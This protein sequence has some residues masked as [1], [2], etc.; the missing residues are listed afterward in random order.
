MKRILA[1]IMFGCC[2]A[3]TRAAAV[4]RDDND[5]KVDVESDR[6]FAL[7]HMR[8]AAADRLIER[9]DEIRAYKAAGFN[10]IVL[11]DADDGLLKSEER[12]AYETSFARAHGF[13]VV[14]GKGTEPLT[15][16]TSASVTSNAVRRPRRALGTAPLRGVSDDEIRERLRLWDQYAN[17]LV[18]GAFFLH[19]D[20]FYIRTPVERQRHLYQ[21]AHET[22]PD[23]YVFGMIGEGG[24]NA[25]DEEIATY[26][27]PKAFDHL[28]LIMYP[29]NTGGAAT[30]MPIDNIASPD[31][32][33]DMKVYVRRYLGVMGEK[34]IKR[35]R[36]EQLTVLV[37]QAFAYDGE[38]AGHFPRAADITI[39]AT[40]GSRCLREIPGQQTNRSMA[41][42]LWDGSRGGMFGLW[43]RNDWR[44]AAE[45]ANRANL[46]DGDK[47][48]GHNREK[49]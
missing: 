38:P 46:I 36:R 34:F 2:L 18:I 15:I 39:E 7:Q 25:T 26:F 32:D 9:D 13:H 14:L 17:D 24:F 6:T 45:K 4:N 1:V 5:R 43:Q 27:D 40:F 28:L 19:D 33:A 31:P 20:A 12:I 30:G 48:P 35:L 29:L 23:W 37:I 3:F 8:I 42:F 47:E 16:E 49:P 11:Y 44:G 22:V 21:L 10:T 41:Y